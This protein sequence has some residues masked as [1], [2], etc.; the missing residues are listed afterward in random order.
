MDGLR[1]IESDLSKILTNLAK[2]PNRQFTEEHLVEKEQ[3]TKDYIVKYNSIA[4]VVQQKDCKAVKNEFQSSVQRV[5]GLRDDICALIRSKRDTSD[6]T[7]DV[8][9]SD[10][11]KVAASL[12][13]ITTE[14]VSSKMA[15]ISFKDVEDALDRFDGTSSKVAV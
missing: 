15:T 5:K 13:V 8:I 2:N 14:G 11:K 3:L 9:V 4:K 7:E 12:E 10:E 6:V 1:D